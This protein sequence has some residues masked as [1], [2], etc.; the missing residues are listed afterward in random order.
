MIIF[1]EF[2]AEKFSYFLFKD[3]LTDSVDENHTFYTGLNACTHLRIYF[4]QLDV[5]NL[6]V[7]QTCRI[8]NQ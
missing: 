6:S 4:F 2:A 8:V 3:T 1:R 7:T 5:Q